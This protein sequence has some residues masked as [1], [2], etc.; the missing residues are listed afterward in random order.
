MAM[1]PVQQGGEFSSMREWNHV[2]GILKT[3]PFGPGHDGFK[4]PDDV[5]DRSGR[6]AA[7]DQQCRNRDRCIITQA[8]CLGKNGMD[9]LGDHTGH[10]GH[11]LLHRR[12]QG[13]P[14]AGAVPVIH[15]EGHGAVPGLFTACCG[16][17]AHDLRQMRGLGEQMIGVRTIVA[18]QKKRRW[19]DQRQGANPFRQQGGKSQGDRTAEGMS[20]QVNRFA[21]AG[22]CFCNQA[23]MILQGNRPAIRPWPGLAAAK[24]LRAQDAP[25]APG[26]GRPGFAHLV[27]VAAIGARAMQQSSRASMAGIAASDRKTRRKNSI[28]LWFM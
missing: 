7:A 6:S 13:G 15:E 9:I 23:H 22:Q 1:H 24:Q 4:A 14:S 5:A 3:H 2:R 25:P 27:P 12:R 26:D 20:D 16:A 21:H 11:R 28:D 19:F 18:Q 10:V 17:A 8:R